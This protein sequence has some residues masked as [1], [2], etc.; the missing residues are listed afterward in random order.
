MHFVLKKPRINL[1]RYRSL[2]QYIADIYI[3]VSNEHQIQCVVKGKISF[4]KATDARGN[5][6]PT[7]YVY[8][9]D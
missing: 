4:A 6:Q 8:K 5:L 3:V 9:K 2:S 7:I 1:R